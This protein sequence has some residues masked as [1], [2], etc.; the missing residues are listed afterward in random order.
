MKKIIIGIIFLITSSS[1]AQLSEDAR[2]NSMGRTSVSNSFNIG[3]LD[4]NPANLIYNQQFDNA[5]L[6]IGLFSSLGYILNSDFASYDFYNKYF[7]GDGEGNKKLLT[8]QEKL[9]I[10]N[11]SKNTS[12]N[13]N[14]SYKL[15]AITYSADDIGSFGLSVS[16]KIFGKAFIPTDLSEFALFGNEVNRTYDFSEFNTN[17]A[18][19]RQINVSFARSLHEVAPGLAFGISVKPTIGFQYL[20]TYENEIKV[21]TN[22]SNEITGSGMG[23]FRSAGLDNQFRPVSGFSDIAGFG[24]G[25]DIGLSLKVN[26]EI[27]AGLSVTDIG[28]VNWSNNA[29]QIFYN[30]NIHITD[31]S[32]DNQIDSLLNAF[33]QKEEPIQSFTSSLPM[34]IR[35]GITYRILEKYNTRSSGIMTYERANISLEYLQ[36][37]SD[38][39]AGSTLDPRVSLGSE[40]FLS[41]MFKVRTGIIAGGEDKIALSIG[42]GGQ[43]G[44]VSVNIGTHNILDIFSL[45]SSSRNSLMLT[46]T[47]GFL[48]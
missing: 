36:G 45:K 40:I 13:A 48:D 7:T 24:M 42:G 1:F 16:D 20:E 35:A 19:L 25:F 22:D 39:Y 34:N 2:L 14:A 38:K 28:W 46:V 4:N 41:R 18:K 12:S 11:A 10:F 3:A 33:K 37:I 29:K 8:Q 23:I 31:L 5:K 26:D 27:T 9:D 21:F 15:F 17:F 32:D 44:P 6:H 47:A 30:A 43:F